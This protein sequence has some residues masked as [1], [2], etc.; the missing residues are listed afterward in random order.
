MS[1]YDDL[2][3]AAAVTA[4]LDKF[5]P[6]ILADPRTSPFFEG[7]NIEGLKRRVEPFMAMALGGPSD[8]HGPPLRQSHARL[9]I[10]GLGP[11][12]V[13]RVP[14]TFRGRH[15]GAGC[16][17]REDRGG[18]ADLPRS[19]QRRFEPL[20]DLLPGGELYDHPLW[21]RARPRTGDR[22]TWAPR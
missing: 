10:Q 9:R 1:L 19:A 18:H 13:P 17:S 8:Y 4:A 3:G 21:P 2:G 6:K 22:L 11:Q 7:V 5:Y 15:E 12:R 14:G 16:A 20:S